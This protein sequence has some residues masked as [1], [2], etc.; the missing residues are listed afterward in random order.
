[1][2]T[3]SIVMSGL[4]A[5]ALLGV[6]A[7]ETPKRA[8]AVETTTAAKPSPAADVAKLE[9][10][11]AARS[12]E[13]KARDKWRHPVETLAFFDVAPNMTV[14]EA[15]PGRGWY[16]RILL[17]Y[18]AENGR[19]VGVNYQDEMWPLILPNPT[20]ELVARLST[21]SETFPEEAAQIAE[22]KNPV[23]AYEFGNPP[24][25]LVGE[26]D[27]VLFIRALHNFNRAG[28]DFGAEAL[29]D[30]YAVLKPGGVLG[31]VQHAAPEGAEGAAADGTVGYMSEANV[32][33]MV[34]A[35]GFTLESKSDVNRNPA[36]EPAP[37]EIVWRLPPTYGL[38]DKDRE[39]YAAIG[40]SNRMTL[41][42][43]KP[44]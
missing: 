9:A 21:W 11:V 28:G 10:I 14:V 39:I 43:R 20:P 1:M 25:D 8:Q 37:G 32:I 16:T 31:V 38:G 3:Q 26:A 15:L 2:N 33:A 19:Y 24:A 40:E 42:F 27:V 44:R 35:A 36:D 18:L 30:A 6:A 29:A 34:E 22:T 12:D 13:A 41:R 17:P 4:S 23:T 5:L 7:C